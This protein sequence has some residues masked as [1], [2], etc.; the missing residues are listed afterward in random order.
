MSSGKS[1]RRWK[2][3]LLSVGL[4]GLQAVEEATKESIEQVAVCGRVAVTSDAAA[5]IVGSSTH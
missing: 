2:G 3:S 5:V 1:I 4:I